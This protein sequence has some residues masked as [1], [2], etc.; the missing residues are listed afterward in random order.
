MGE[1][2]Q[3][4]CSTWHRHRLFESDLPQ[5][6]DVGQQPVY[7]AFKGAPHDFASRIKE[8]NPPP[9][10]GGGALLAI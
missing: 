10:A 3:R 5:Q 1:V 2:S 8:R 7:K 9:L 6:A 4:V